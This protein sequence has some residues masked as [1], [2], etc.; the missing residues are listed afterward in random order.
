MGKSDWSLMKRREVQAGG[1][2]HSAYLAGDEL[3]YTWCFSSE[4]DASRG[5]LERVADRQTHHDNRHGT[6]PERCGY[7]RAKSRCVQC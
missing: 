5:S 6:V 7:G 2:P 3:V 4:P 1:E